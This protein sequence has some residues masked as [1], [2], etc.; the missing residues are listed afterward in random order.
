MVP[1]SDKKLRRII[2]HYQQYISLQLS[3][4]KFYQLFSIRTLKI[5]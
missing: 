1:W 2:F 4:I 3:L 5:G